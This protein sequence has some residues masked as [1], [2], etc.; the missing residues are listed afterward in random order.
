VLIYNRGLRSYRELPLR[1]GEFGVCTRNEPSGALH[2]II[3]SAFHPG[4][5]PHIL[6]RGAIQ[7]EVTARLRHC[8]K[9]LRRLRLHRGRLQTRDAPSEKGRR[10]RA[11]DKAERALQASLDSSGLGY[12][13]LPGEARSKRPKIEYHL[14]DSIGRSWQCGTMQVDF[15]MP[16]LL[17]AEYA[18]GTIRARCRSC[19]TGHRRIHGAIHRD[20]H[21]ALRGRHAAVACAGAVM[22]LNIS[23]GSR[24]RHAGPT[25]LAAGYRCEA[26]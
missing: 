14:K 6:H 1:Y 5:R 24:L 4:R 8:C 26:D 3:A 12:D 22:V 23:E 10:R 19:C 16:G 20:S 15:S 18:A 2:G 25:A 11:L 7:P 21:R 13:V 17:G 9:R